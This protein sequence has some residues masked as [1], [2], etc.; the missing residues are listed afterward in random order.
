MSTDG[1]WIRKPYKP[2]ENSIASIR[3]C[4]NCLKLPHNQDYHLKELRQVS[5]RPTEQSDKKVW[6]GLKVGGTWG[7]GWGGI[8]AKAEY[9]RGSLLGGVGGLRSDGM[10]GHRTLWR[11]RNWLP[12][13]ATVG[14]KQSKTNNTWV[15]SSF[16]LDQAIV[17]CFCIKLRPPTENTLPHRD[18]RFH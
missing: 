4:S 3:L 8:L 2:D 10:G 9:G 14:L 5:K 18:W 7:E 16:T 12:T 15:T 17:F 11:K 1:F 13:V 6:G